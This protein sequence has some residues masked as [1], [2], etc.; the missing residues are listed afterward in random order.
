[1]VETV[2]V[3]VDGGTASEAAM[4]WSLDRAAHCDIH[5]DVTTVIEPNAHPQNET[6]ADYRLRRETA[7][8][9]TVG[10]AAPSLPTQVIE[11]SV[12]YGRAVD[13]LIQASRN[14][15]LLVIGNHPTSLL[16]GMVHGTL[17]LQ[18]A[19][20]TGCT[21]VVVPSNWRPSGSGVVVAWD[22]DSSADAALMFAAAEAHRRHEQ[23]TIVH[24]WKVPSAQIFD[25]DGATIAFDAALELE[26]NVLADAAVTVRRAYPDLVVREA[27]E[28]GPAAVEVIAAAHGASLL[29]VGTHSRHATASFLLGSVSH[30]ALIN[31][32]APVAIVPSAWKPT[33]LPPQ[34]RDEDLL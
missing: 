25:A 13:A 16:A 9:S 34:L 7:L 14:C 10:R 12:I 2:M 6:E 11:K 29:I 5:L 8:V 23:L 20:Q 30:S 18:L 33:A 26:H 19:G 28:P 3:A 27:L 15:D 17:P 31:M 24:S 1:M 32:P 4:A 21:T 22:D